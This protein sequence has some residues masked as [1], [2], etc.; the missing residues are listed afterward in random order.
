MAV[1]VDPFRCDRQS[2]ARPTYPGR[3]LL[4]RRNTRTKRGIAPPVEKVPSRD[5]PRHARRD[6]PLPAATD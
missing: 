6:T 4:Q 3:S 1:G 2:D 5:W